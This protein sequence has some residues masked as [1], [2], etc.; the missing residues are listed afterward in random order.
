MAEAVYNN[1]GMMT[2]E[3]LS[4]TSQT[5]SAFIKALEYQYKRIF[6]LSKAESLQAVDCLSEYRKMANDSVRLEGETLL[7]STELGKK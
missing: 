1:F 6:A 7:P 5:T 2:T 4:N 3:A